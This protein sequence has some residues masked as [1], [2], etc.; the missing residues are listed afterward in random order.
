MTSSPS[1]S[2]RLDAERVRFPVS[3]SEHKKNH[4]TVKPGLKKVNE[5]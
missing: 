2:S 5:D 1:V 3:V 4:L